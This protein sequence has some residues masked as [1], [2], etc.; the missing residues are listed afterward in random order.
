[1]LIFSVQL[2][3]SVTHIYILFHILFYY[4]SSQN[5]EYSSLC[6]TIGPCWLSILCLLIVCL[7]WS[8]TLIPSLYSFLNL[9]PHATSFMEPSVSALSNSPSVSTI[10]ESQDAV[11]SAWMGPQACGEPWWEVRGKRG[12][13]S[14]NFILGSRWEVT[15]GW[16][17]PLTKACCFSAGMHPS[18]SALSE[19]SL[20]APA[21]TAPAAPGPRVPRCGSQ[22]PHLYLQSSF[23]K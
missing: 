22:P 12:K 7:C 20:Q 6:Y 10:S 3:D 5:T 9:G 8:Q 4:A 1:M 17:W 19:H 18:R 15:S 16:S 2:S 11:W 23:C 14:G 21:V 13:R